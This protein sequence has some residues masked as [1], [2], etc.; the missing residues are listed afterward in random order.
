MPQIQS[1]LKVFNPVIAKI[2]VK[3]RSFRTQAKPSPSPKRACQ[4]KL[5]NVVRRQPPDEPKKY[6]PIKRKS[7]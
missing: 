5:P 3:E 4:Q 1:Y 6:L 2:D 7:I